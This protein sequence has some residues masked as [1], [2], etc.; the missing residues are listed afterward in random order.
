MSPRRIRITFRAQGRSYTLT[1]DR[2]AVRRIEA[3]TGLPVAVALERMKA[4][5]VRHLRVVF[6]AA[7]HGAHPEIA[8]HDV[9]DLI[10]DLVDSDE[11][12]EVLSRFTESC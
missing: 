1:F 3:Q 7:L 8:L 5:S 4:R 6:W 12:L 11:V 2:A 9:G 10:D